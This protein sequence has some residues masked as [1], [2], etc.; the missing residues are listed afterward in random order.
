MML[1]LYHLNLAT[2][3]LLVIFEPSILTILSGIKTGLQ[4]LKLFLFTKE[5]NFGLKTIEIE[6]Y[7]R[8]NVMA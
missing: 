4:K 5:L 7:F 6:E 3:I 2:K 1:K 8:E